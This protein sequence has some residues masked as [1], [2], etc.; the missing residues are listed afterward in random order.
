[1]HEFSQT[2]F[3]ACNVSQFDFGIE[4]MGLKRCRPEL[5]L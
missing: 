2:H 4:G 1:M 3:L 5:S